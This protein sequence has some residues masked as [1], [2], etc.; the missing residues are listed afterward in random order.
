MTD[1]IIGLDREGEKQGRSQNIMV[2]SSQ[3]MIDMLQ[4]FSLHLYFY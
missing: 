3:Y 1:K 4:N 2:S